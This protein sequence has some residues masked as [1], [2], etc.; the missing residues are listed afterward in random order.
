MKEL[1]KYSDAFQLESKIF[2]EPSLDGLTGWY[3]S[4][5]M[6]AR[7]KYLEAIEINEHFAQ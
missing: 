4:G 5:K 1:L 6:E 3:Y 7:R 2:V